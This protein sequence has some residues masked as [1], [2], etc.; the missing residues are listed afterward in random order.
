MESKDKKT[1]EKL[2]R[3]LGFWALFIYGVGDILGAGIYALFGKVV[4]LGGSESWIAFVLALG[5]AFLTAM[6]YAELAARFPRSGG[7]ASFTFEGLKSP[8]LSLV[9]GWMVLWSGMV[10]MATI[11]QAFALQ[12]LVWFPSASL[13]FLVVGFLSVLAVI[14]FWGIYYTS[15]VNMVFTAIEF[16][17]I[18]IVLYAAV[19]FFESKEFVEYPAFVPASLSEI[20]QAAGIAF[21]ALIGFED[22]ANIA[23][24]VKLP[25]KNLPRAILSAVG[26]A[27]VT[28][29]AVAYTTVKVI[30]PETLGVSETPLLDVVEK[31]LPSFPLPVFAFIALFAMAN[32]ALLNFVMG[33]RLLYGMAQDGLGPHV[34]GRVHRLRQTPYVAIGVIFCVVLLLALLFDLKMLAA[35]T[36]ALLLTVFSLVHTALLCLKK[37][38]TSHK[39]FSVFFLFPAIGIISNICLLYFLPFESKLGALA[40][41][42]SGGALISLYH[43]AFK[44]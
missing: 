28:Y 37:R 27:G 10:S 19:A 39:G 29:T 41:A 20:F 38:T 4:Q 8:L 43:F 17:G 21:F 12:S 22:M 26:F 30:A 1:K 42:T 2:A 3:V 35:T 32:T 31:G 11:S 36:S 16:S 13:G 24:E 7:A 44:K 33:S 34:L 14:N 23:E 15:L 6:S 18:V 5:T 25:K 40:V 9:V